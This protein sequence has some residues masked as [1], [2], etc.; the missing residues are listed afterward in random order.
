[1]SSIGNVSEPRGINSRYETGLFSF[2]FPLDPLSPEKV[3]QAVIFAKRNFLNN[4]IS[5]RINFTIQ[6]L[7]LSL[8]RGISVRIEISVL[9]SSREEFKTEY[10]PY[11]LI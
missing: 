7:K 5:Q 4:K 2:K 1:M 9:K 10:V 8:A 3:T 11:F 6:E